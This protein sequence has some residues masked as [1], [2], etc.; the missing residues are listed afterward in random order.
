VPDLSVSGDNFDL[1][2]GDPHD[3]TTTSETR[4]ANTIAEPTPDGYRPCWHKISLI[5]KINSYAQSKNEQESKASNLNI[6]R[7]W[8]S[9]SQRIA[10]ICASSCLAKARC[11]IKL[12]SESK[13]GVYRNRREKGAQPLAPFGEGHATPREGEDAR[14]PLMAPN[15]RSPSWADLL[16]HLL[17]I[18]DLRSSTLRRSLIPS[19]EP[20]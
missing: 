1:V 4:S 19:H 20:E 18:L 8:S 6:T 11:K 17:C 12:K 16:G 3:P 7:R 14:L 15:P 2:G 9:E 10:R 13:R 5:T